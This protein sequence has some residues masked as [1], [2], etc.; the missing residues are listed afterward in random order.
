MLFHLKV[1]SDLYLQYLLGQT[2]EDIT[3][4]CKAQLLH[5]SSIL[6]CKD[7]LPNPKKSNTVL[8]AAFGSEP[9]PGAELNANT[10]I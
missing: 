5:S 2:V 8:A 1:K 6:E 10:S 9:E 3:I 4:L 7:L